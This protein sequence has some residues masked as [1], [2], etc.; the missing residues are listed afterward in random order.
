MSWVNECVEYLSLLEGGVRVMTDVGDGWVGFIESYAKCRGSEP[1]RTM[2]GVGVALAA[3]VLEGTSC[4]WENL[5]KY[6]TSNVL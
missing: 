3:A 6:T 2:V 5:L 1:G 4:L